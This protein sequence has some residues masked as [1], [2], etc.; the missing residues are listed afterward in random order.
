MVA[1]LTSQKGFDL[2]AAAMNDLMKKNIQLIILGYGEKHYQEIFEK[3]KTQY[4]GRFDIELAF[5]FSSEHKIVAGAD[6]ILVPSR[7]EPCGLTQMHALRYGTVPVVRETGGLKDTIYEYDP[8]KSAGNGFRFKASTVLD[9]LGAVDQALI[10]YK[11]KKLWELLIK[12]GMK[13]DHSWEKSAQAYKEL[14]E[15]ITQNPGW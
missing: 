13:E 4:P 6:I 10:V 1:R 7:Y 12:N 15:N 5:D 3:M 14:Y 8:D 9:F 2:V 11:Q